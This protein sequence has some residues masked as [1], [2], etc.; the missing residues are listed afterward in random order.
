MLGNC[1]LFAVEQGQANKGGELVDIALAG[2]II[3]S[4]LGVSGVIIT[5]ILRLPD[6][7]N[8]KSNPNS[9]PNPSKCPAHSGVN[10]NITNHEKLI[11]KLDDGQTRI[12]QS[13]DGMKKDMNTNTATL[14]K[15]INGKNKN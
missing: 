13:I 7:N 14:L 11:K 3:S 10:T 12:W 15:A 9:T 5:G 6:R 1:L 2:V 8:N 4:V